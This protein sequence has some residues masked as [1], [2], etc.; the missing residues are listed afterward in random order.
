M[1][2][3]DSKELNK[4]DRYRIESGPGAGEE[5]ECVSVYPTDDGSVWGS[6][7]TATGTYPTRW[8]HLAPSEESSG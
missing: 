4:G 8:Q 7:Q 1:P 3:N 6:I 5:G 2:L